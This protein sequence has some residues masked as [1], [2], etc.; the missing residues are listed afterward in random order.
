M[1]FSISSREVY[2]SPF[3]SVINDGDPHCTFTTV[4]MLI[5]PIKC[6]ITQNSSSLPA[7][8]LPAFLSVFSSLLCVP[9]Y[10]SL[11]LGLPMPIWGCLICKCL[12]VCF[13]GLIVHVTSCCRIEEPYLETGL[14]STAPAFL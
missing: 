6:L 3:T 9:L 13:V 11:S 14:L 12:V 2:F 5:C 8:R 1:S 4:C 10:H 7:F